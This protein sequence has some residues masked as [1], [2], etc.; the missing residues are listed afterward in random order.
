MI[1]VLSDLHF[2]D[3]GGVGG[4]RSSSNVAPGAFEHL[5][6]QIDAMAER[7]RVESA[8]IVVLNGDVLDLLLSERWFQT[9]HRPYNFSDAALAPEVAETALALA[10][11]V[12]EENRAAWSLLRRPGTRY[13][14]LYGNHDRLLRMP[15]LEPVR[16]ELRELL[17]GQVE[18]CDEWRDE[19]HQLVVRHGHELDWTNSEFQVARAFEG[20]EARD[21]D[22]RSLATLG[23]WVAIDIGARLPHLAQQ[24]FDSPAS[25]WR[26]LSEPTRRELY[27]RLIDLDDLRPQGAI[28]NWLVRPVGVDRIGAE[29]GETDAVLE[30]L[31]DLM[32]ELVRE[33]IPLIQPWLEH[34]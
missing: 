25:R 24:L 26:K 11:A 34:Q 6:R 22:R 33:A 18:F 30:F 29:L 19:R 23:D 17:G 7:A 5:W 27:E 8:P 16:R 32:N 31:G 10:R 20:L 4:A 15:S 12:V 9:R 13:I 2:Q 28:L 14:Y 21:P 3:T 1:V